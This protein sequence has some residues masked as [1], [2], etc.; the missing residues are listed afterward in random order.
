MSEPL[1]V[2]IVGCGDIAGGYDARGGGEAVRTHAG[3][4]SRDP[5]FQ[6]RACVEPDTQRRAAFMARWG[7]AAGYDD[8][9]ACLAAEGGFDVASLC[10]PTAFHADALETLLGADVRLVFAEKPLTGE[11]ARSRQVVAAYA[12]AGKPLCVNY[13]R[14]WDKRVRQLRDEIDAD[15]WG[16]VQAIGG[17]YAKGLYNCASHFFDLIHYLVGPLTPRAVLGRVD[18]GRADDPTLS[19]FLETE[20]G[21]PVTLIGTHAELYFPFEIDLVM[22]NGRL[23]LEDLGGRL[24]QRRVRAHPLYAHQPSLDD[25]TFENTGIGLALVRAVD[26]IYDHLATGAEL[27]ST[28]ESALEAEEL[29]ARIMAM[30]PNEGGHA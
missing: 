16:G 20:A 2:L 13:L 18:D 26:N 9:A 23:S 21:A 11:A 8:L 29:C 7:I 3:A 19:V 25:G 30:V 22:E 6:M 1:A 5:R 4:Y 12:A 17:L 15:D 28:A 27:V 14:R 24:R 10:L